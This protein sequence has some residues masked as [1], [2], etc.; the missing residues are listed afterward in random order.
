MLVQ[1]M[2]TYGYCL[3][4]LRQILLL[5]IMLAMASYG[6]ATV[7][8]GKEPVLSEENKANKA[9]KAN[10][11]QLEQMA[12]TV[13]LERRGYREPMVQTVKMEHKD[14]KVRRDQRE[15]KV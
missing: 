11:A 1:K 12:R 9:Y 6:I 7:H 3:T 8:N 13:Q 5:N 2:Q 14:Q 10:K 4:Q 15:I